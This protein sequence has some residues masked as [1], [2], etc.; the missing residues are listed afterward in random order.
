[1]IDQIHV[2]G[3]PPLVAL[4]CIISIAASHKETFSIM[5]IN[6]SRAYFHAK[7]QRLVLVRLLVE[8]RVGPDAG[9]N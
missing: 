4:K 8:I 7:S 1:M 6:V 5:H 2:Q 9:E 3:P